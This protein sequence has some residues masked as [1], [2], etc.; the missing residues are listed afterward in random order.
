MRQD[1][2]RHITALNDRELERFVDEWVGAKSASF[3]DHKRFGSGGDMGRDVVGYLTDRRMSGPWVNFQ[4]KQLLKPVSAAMAGLELGKIFWHA[5]KGAFSLPERYVI[6]APRGFKRDVAALIDDPDTFKPTFLA[7][8]D[9]WCKSGIV[10]GTQTL[11]NDDIRALIEGY[12]FKAVEL[13]DAEK[14]LQDPYIVPTLVE[15]FG[16]DPGM[17]PRG[18]VPDTMQPEET[19]FSAELLE[20]YG[21]REGTL[22]S[23]LTEVARH[24][25]HGAHFVLQRRRFFDAGAFRRFYRDNTPGSFLVGFDQDIHDGVVDVY[26]RPRSDRLHRHDEV[27]IQ[28]SSI[29]PAGILGHHS[30]VSVRQGT[31]HH[32]VNEGRLSWK[33]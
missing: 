23:N 17:P 28:A 33:A 11:L 3:S 6:V 30:T 31:C 19:D 29:K 14:L 7:N 10:A 27:M 24:P 4:C 22:F 2:A 12:D 21:E 32:F 26:S 16:Y 1:Y 25:G 13:W 5:S 20:L 8:W 18:Q 15:W 9:R